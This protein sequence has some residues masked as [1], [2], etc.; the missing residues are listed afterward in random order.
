MYL[1][2]QQS[3][4]TEIDSVEPRSSSCLRLTG[5]DYL[6][7]ALVTTETGDNI[8]RGLTEYN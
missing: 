3:Y 8:G 4:K 1:F 6:W 7:P 5:H 2:G